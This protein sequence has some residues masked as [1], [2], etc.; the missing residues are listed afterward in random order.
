VA[1]LS[2]SGVKSAEVPARAHPTRRHPPLANSSGS[3]LSE[4]DA[5]KITSSWVLNVLHGG[6]STF[7]PPRSFPLVIGASLQ[8]THLRNRGQASTTF[9]E[10]T[11][12]R[13][14]RLKPGCVAVK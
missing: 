11:S 9:L 14:P 3:L 7:R 12:V 10:A 5:R 6:F 13:K 1:G 2:E 8:P 4:T